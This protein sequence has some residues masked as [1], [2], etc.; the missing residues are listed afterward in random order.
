M[1]LENNLIVNSII[2]MIITI[3]LLFLRLLIII[4]IFLDL[5]GLNINM[6]IVLFSAPVAD[7]TFLVFSSYF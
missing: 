6:D 4:T 7:V 2:L 1:D 3:L 5:L